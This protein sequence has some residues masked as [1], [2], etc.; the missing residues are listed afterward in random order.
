MKPYYLYKITNNL[1]SKVYIGITGYPQKRKQQHFYARKYR[2]RQIIHTAI[3]KYGVD[4]FTFDIV[5]IG[6]KDYILDLEIKLISAY[7]ATE[8]KFGYNIKSGGEVGRGY[9]ISQTKKDKFYY[10]SGFW[11]PNIRTCL[12]ALNIDKSTFQRWRKNNS[13]GD[14][15]RPNLREIDGR[16]FTY[17]AGFWWPSALKA[18]EILGINYSTVISRIRSGHTEQKE[19]RRNQAGENNHMFGIDTFLHPCSV[20][21]IILGEVYNSIKD[22]TA[23]TGF[24][25]YIINQRIKQGHNDFAYYNSQ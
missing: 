14:I 13:L 25:K 6:P 2:S 7:R 18:S 20:K 24:S 5:C 11:F 22:A 17:V 23:A 12:K 16:M 19:R 4:N 8:K 21:V 15:T 3:D 10:V 9:S 1:S